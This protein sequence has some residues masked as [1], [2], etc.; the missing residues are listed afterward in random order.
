MPRWIA[1]NFILYLKE[2]ELNQAPVDWLREGKAWEKKALVA[3]QL[4]EK[5]PAEP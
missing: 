2:I 1:F 3:I 4:A 5:E